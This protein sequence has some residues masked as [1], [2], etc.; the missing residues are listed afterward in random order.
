MQKTQ[1]INVVTS[2]Q[3]VQEHRTPAAENAMTEVA[4]QYL[5]L[6][7]SHQIV[8]GSL[9]AATSVVTTVVK[10]HFCLDRIRHVSFTSVDST[11]KLAERELR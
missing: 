9:Q 5:Q 4:G 10:L 3:R 11:E 2:E 7:S 1:S 8:V 6:Q